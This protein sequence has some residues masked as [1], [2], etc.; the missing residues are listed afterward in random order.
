MQ[1]QSLLRDAVPFGTSHGANI[2]DVSKDS[3]CAK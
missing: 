1:Y 2:D 3:G